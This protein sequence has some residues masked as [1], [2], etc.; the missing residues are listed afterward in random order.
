MRFAEMR[1]SVMTLREFKHHCGAEFWG[2]ISLARF[3]ASL[4][5]LDGHVAKYSA[6][7]SVHQNT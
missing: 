1:A 2:R 3:S 7:P 4:R 6:K 5:E